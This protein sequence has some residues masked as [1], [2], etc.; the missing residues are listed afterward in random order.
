MMN[1]PIFIRARI[2]MRQAQNVT[3]QSVEIC[4]KFQFIHFNLSTARLTLELTGRE[5][6]AFNIFGEDN[7]ESIAV[8]R[9]G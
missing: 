9:S 5:H 1:R 7:D 3:K 6:T 2:F 4:T 8:E